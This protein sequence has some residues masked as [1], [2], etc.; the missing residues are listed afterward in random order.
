MTNWEKLQAGMIYNDF[1]DDLF[2]RRI[3][4][5]K[6]FRQY[7]KTDDGETELRQEIM[8]KLFKSVG[9]NVW[10]EPDFRCE[11]GKNI[12]I[13]DNVYINFGCVILDCS[14]I[15]IGENTLLGPNVGI[16][17]ANHSIDAEERINGGCFGKPI[18]I[19]KRVWLG[20]DVKVIAGVTIGDDSIIGT[21]SIVTKDIPSGVIAVGNPCKILRKITESDKT[22]YLKTIQ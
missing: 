6:L 17:S 11:F 21:G 7:N 2:Q 16:Y 22:D 20:G 10:I 4:A 15:T 1:D 3:Y 19:G 14:E 18:H 9:K 13:G 5:K 12:T 8:S